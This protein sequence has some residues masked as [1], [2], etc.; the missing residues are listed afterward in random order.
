LRFRAGCF[1]RTRLFTGLAGAPEAAAG[2]FFVTPAIE[3]N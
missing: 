3:R 1:Q 2:Y